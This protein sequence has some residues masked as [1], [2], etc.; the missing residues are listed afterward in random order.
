MHGKSG[1]LTRARKQTI[2][3]FSLTMD[4]SQRNP[5]GYLRQ[6]ID[7]EIKSLEESVRAPRHR[8]NALALSSPGGERYGSENCNC[9]PGAIH[10]H[11]I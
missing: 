11:E 4:P 7:A 5:R 3:S 9:K 2:R 8:R 1:Q 6:V 10:W